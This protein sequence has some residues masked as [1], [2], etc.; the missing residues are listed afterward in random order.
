[1]SVASS[2]TLKLFIEMNNPSNNQSCLSNSI[3]EPAIL[4]DFGI[5]SHPGIL[6]SPP[7]IIAN[8]TTNLDAETAKTNSTQVWGD[9]F[10]RCLNSEIMQNLTELREPMKLVDVGGW[11][12]GPKEENFWFTQVLMMLVMVIRTSIHIFGWLG[13]KWQD[14][15]KMSSF[16][17]IK[18]FFSTL[19]LLPMLVLLTRWTAMFVFLN[20]II[21][22]TFCLFHTWPASVDDTEVDDQAYLSSISTRFGDD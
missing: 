1:M 4:N 2:S 3:A 22:F 12:T 11:T 16:V 8:C 21:P 13:Y 20:A 19:L 9:A 7:I 17:I 18:A 14:V 10:Y 6:K 5:Q 15:H